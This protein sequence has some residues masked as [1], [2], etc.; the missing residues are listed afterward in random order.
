[1]IARFVV[2]C[3]LLVALLGSRL[4]GAQPTTSADITNLKKQADDLKKRVDDLDNDL[5]ALTQAVET[6]GASVDKLQRVTRTL[7]DKDAA[8]AA[9]LQH[10]DGR[11][12]KIENDIQKEL[13]HVNRILSSISKDEGSGNHILA[14]NNTMKIKEAREQVT[15][16]VLE[17][18]KQR[19]TGTLTILNKMT[20][21]V[22][23]GINGQRNY[24]V[25]P[26]E[27]LVLSDVPVGTV[28]VELVGWGGRTNWTIAPPNYEQNIE[29]VPRNS[30]AR[31]I[32]E[33]P[34]RIIYA[35]P[36][37]V[38]YEGAPSVGMY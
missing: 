11:V 18:L 29:I 3:A 28:M 26:G 17:E 15:V 36:K 38:I 16:A 6:F 32:Y 24:P 30:P 4:T 34:T 8:T 7:T 2:A 22:Q 9:G 20:F 10:L 25:P 35:P 27:K 1:M 14:L 12:A 33:S 23:I 5:K 19:K 21:E 31:I 37:R 13:A